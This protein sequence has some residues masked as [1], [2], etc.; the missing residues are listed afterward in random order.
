M[1]GFT[2][3]IL[4]KIVSEC[5]GTTTYSGKIKTIYIHNL[6]DRWTY[7]VCTAYLFNKIKVVFQND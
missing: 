1:N 6:K 3:D 4:S 2:K 7:N 5:G